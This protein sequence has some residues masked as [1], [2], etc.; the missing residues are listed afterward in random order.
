MAD[1]AIWQPPLQSPKQKGIFEWLAY[2][3][4]LVGGFGCSW[5]FNL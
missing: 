2:K 3:W 1:S 5:E 4:L